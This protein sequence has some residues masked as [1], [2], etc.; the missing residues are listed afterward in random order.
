MHYLADSQSTRPL[1]L[2]IQQKRLPMEMFERIASII[3]PVFITIGVGY[4]Y[5]RLRGENIKSDMTSVNRV[6]MGVLCPLLVFTALAAKDF[7]VGHNSTLI[8]AGVLISIGSGVLAWPVARMFGYDVR[9]F[10]P[11]M[12]YNNCGN[13]GLPLAILAFGPGGLSA[14]VAL[15]MA[16]NLVYFSLGIKI[17][18]T[19]RSGP[20]TPFLRFLASPMMVAMMFGIGFSVLHISLSPPLF[21]AL[22]MLGEACIPIMLFA[23]GVR[24]LDINF[25]S[26][27]IG[28]VG[29]VVCPVGGLMVAWML[30]GVLTLTPDQRGQMYL[31][32]ALP[33]AV[34]CF[35][36]AEQY[37]QEPDKVASIV[38]LGNLAALVFVPAG[39]WLGLQ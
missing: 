2:P 30:D 23:L 12:M 37:Q 31:F 6:S 35:M 25:K 15:F 27:H 11:P 39:L 29:A 7:D 13:M 26:W 17:I 5:A 34:F 19:G 33:P 8:M 3:L 28:L 38:L 24:M 36:V 14:A 9:S 16:C 4:A 20:R 32:A 22:K 1:P 18:E 21:Q 10:I